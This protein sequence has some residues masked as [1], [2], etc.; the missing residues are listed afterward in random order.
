VMRVD[1][2][3]KFPWSCHDEMRVDFLGTK[4]SRGVVI[5]MRV[6]REQ[7]IPVQS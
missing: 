1:L 4:N 3:Q 2:E 7:K 5:V 6:D